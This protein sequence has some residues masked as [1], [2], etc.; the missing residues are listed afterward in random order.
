M[1]E[2]TDLG[3]PE[4]DGKKGASTQQKKNE[5]V[6][7]PDIVVQRDQEIINYFHMF[8]VI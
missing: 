6:V 2:I 3:K 4:V 8:K 1:S 5:P 7:P